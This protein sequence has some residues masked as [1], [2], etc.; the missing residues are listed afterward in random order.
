MKDL[1]KT[2]L[3]DHALEMLME[4]VM[5]GLRDYVVAATIAGSGARKSAD[6]ISFEDARLRLSVSRTGRR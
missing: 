6:I 4:D 3:R 5:K 2:P 1:R